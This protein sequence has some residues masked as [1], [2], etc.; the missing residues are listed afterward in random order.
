MTCLPILS[1]MS[2]LITRIQMALGHKTGSAQEAKERL[3]ALQAQ[4]TQAKTVQETKKAA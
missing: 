3:K 4:T 1:S 2:K